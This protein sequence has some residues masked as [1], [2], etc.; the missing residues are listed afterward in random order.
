MILQTFCFIKK[1]T[2]AARENKRMSKFW[3]IGKSQNHKIN[4]LFKMQLSAI[5]E[6]SAGYFRKVK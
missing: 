6:K 4:F 3:E 2:L 1:F 5:P